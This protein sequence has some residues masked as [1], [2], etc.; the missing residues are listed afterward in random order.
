MNLEEGS[1]DLYLDYSI[2]LAYFTSYA[3]FGG[4]YLWHV[5]LLTCIDNWGYFCTL[6]VRCYCLLVFSLSP[7]LFTPSS[8]WS[9]CEGT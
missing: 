5:A 8:S 9:N 3:L 2:V 1:L 4:M 7:L 6:Q